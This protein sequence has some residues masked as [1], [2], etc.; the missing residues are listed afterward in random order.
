MQ[1]ENDLEEYLEA[2][3]ETTFGQSQGA[4]AKLDFNDEFSWLDHYWKEPTQAESPVGDTTFS[5]PR[6]DESESNSSCLSPDSPSPWQTPTRLHS[7]SGWCVSPHQNTFSPEP[8]GLTAF[9]HHGHNSPPLVRPTPWRPP[10]S[11]PRP[12][13]FIPATPDDRATSSVFKPLATDSGR[14]GHSVFQSFAKGVHR[15]SV[16]PDFGQ[17]A[18]MPLIKRR[19]CNAL[20]RDV[21][22]EAEIRFPQQQVLQ[23]GHIEDASK[24][25]QVGARSFPGSTLLSTSSILCVP[26]ARPE[27]FP[28]PLLEKST[29]E[30]GQE[31]SKVKKD[32][33]PCRGCLLRG[34]LGE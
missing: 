5:S 4:Y 32:P 24:A 14:N 8:P 28:L 12:F 2:I 25:Q 18:P 11:S 20:F 7:G 26:S 23:Q 31:K 27:V 16:V 19:C 33:L 15:I 10:V 13:E 34:K 30:R 1:Q 6:I 21:G 29:P 17:D 3:Q 9:H 22:L